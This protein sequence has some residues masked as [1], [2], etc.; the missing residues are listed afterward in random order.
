MSYG[1]LNKALIA[2]FISS[3]L[4]ACAGTGSL[5]SD[6]NKPTNPSMPR[7]SVVADKQSNKNNNT[8]TINSLIL[9][10]DNGP[11]IPTT[12]A[13][14]ESVA[15]SPHGDLW[16]RL[17]KSFQIQVPTHR[18]QV[19]A[20][21][22]WFL[23]HQ[24]YLNRTAKR[25]APYMHYIMERIQERNLPAELALLPIIE[26]AYS[27]MANSAPG[28]SGLW[29]LMPGTATKFGITQN[30]WY[31][32]RRDIFAS[33]NAALDYFT[34][35]QNYFDNNW[36]LA[37]AAY[38][39]GEGTIQE[40]VRKN[41]R[42]GLS[43]EFWSLPLPQ[44]TQSYVPRLLAL[45]EIIR[46]HHA[47][48][49]NLPPIDD[50]P[51]LGQ[52]DVS[53]QVKLADAA[54]M[55]GISFSE[56]K[57]LNPGYKNWTLDPNGPYKIVLPLDK[58]SSFK[59]KMASN[60]GIIPNDFNNSADG[61]AYAKVKQDETLTGLTENNTSPNVVN[62]T[63]AEDEK[64]LVIS[65]D[66]Q[67]AAP[68]RMAI[69]TPVEKSLPSADQSNPSPQP[70]KT[71]HVV[72]AH[73]TLSAIARHNHVS[74]ANLRIWNHLTE[75]QAIKPGQKLIVNYQVAE[76]IEGDAA[77]PAKTTPTKPNKKSA[78]KT[79]S[80]K[81]N[82]SKKATHH[83]KATAIHTSKAKTHSKSKHPSSSKKPK[84]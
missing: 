43:T 38:D 34:Y 17:S 18:P 9:L 51:Y 61:T 57:L 50:Q 12:L 66:I 35:L 3:M 70:E 5:I 32:G 71:I 31:D 10:N 20:Q 41:A 30:W 33:T 60:L 47:Y 2:C 40:A 8:Q 77:E 48:P 49:I 74:M 42:Q 36:L 11:A 76:S 80:S 29:Q 13:L 19:Q 53:S 54:H 84:P 58:I 63:T 27:P 39:A 22:A 6:P 46:N 25:A 72:K 62:E 69:E 4:C 16:D 81:R 26:S 52:V 28:A 21:I 24:D 82:I 37:L 56:L 59:L 55:A 67:A 75:K 65:S 73:E 44:E 79:I 83:L 15:L 1:T 78:I 23:R 64:P 45:A 7:H 14:P 68:T